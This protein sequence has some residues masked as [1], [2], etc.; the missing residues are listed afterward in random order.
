MGRFKSDEYFDEIHR[1]L[2]QIDER[3]IEKIG[4]LAINVREK[5]GKVIVVGNGG[6]AGIASH[7]AV[8][9]TKAA[10]VESTTF[11][12]NSLVTCFANDYG[13]ENWL[14]ECVTA[15]GKKGD[16]LIAISSSGESVN[17]LNAVSAARDKDICVVTLSG[18][19][20]KNSLSISG[21]V[22]LYADS[23]NYNV[24]EM[25][26]MGWLLA[27]VEWLVSKKV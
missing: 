1:L 26:H 10:G 9:L 19:K 8:D 27:I 3:L 15:Y 5:K 7:V 23:M 22:N 21:D 2:S 25:V 6:S 13:F 20:S 17:I 11:S 24:V 14:K 12:D 18:F 4:M 16:L